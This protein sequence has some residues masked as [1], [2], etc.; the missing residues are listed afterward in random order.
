MLG[1]D[2]KKDVFAMF[3]EMIA[4]EVLATE[5]RL[6]E[7]ADA[8]YEEATKIEGEAFRFWLKRV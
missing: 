4:K 1:Y 6:G 5:V 2:G 7:I 3:G 8:E